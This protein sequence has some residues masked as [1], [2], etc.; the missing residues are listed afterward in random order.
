ME[1]RLLP[2]WARDMEPQRFA[3]IFDAGDALRFHY[4]TA[5]NDYY[6][7]QGETFTQMLHRL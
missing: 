2:G 5:T 7:W 3:Q 4:V 6:D 1:S